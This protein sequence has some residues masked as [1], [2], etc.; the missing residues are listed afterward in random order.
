MKAFKIF[1][2]ISLVF[3]ALFCEEKIPEG[4]ERSEILKVRLTI[5]DNR[6][7]FAQENNW[8]NRFKL[9]PY[10]MRMDDY[11][12][13]SQWRVPF[14]VSVH[15][16]FDEAIDGRK[17]IFI[18]INLWPEDF[19][20]MWKAQLIYTDTSSTRHLTIPPGD[21][22]TLYTG[23]KL[24]WDQKDFNGKSIHR[25]N[26]FEPIWIECTEFDSFIK[27]AKNELVPWRYC[28]T[29]IL[30]PVDTVVV[31][32]QP[33]KLFAQAEIQIF[34]NYRIVK[35]DTVEFRIHYFFPGEG[36]RPKFWCEERMRDP[37]DPPCPFGFP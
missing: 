15:N 28:D 22:L 17:W 33:K 14:N 26:S 18:Q 24:T 20:E 12:K 31:F 32:G 11:V 7:D 34:K 19:N 8:E 9:P 2:I 21:S 29:L 36:F 16:D 1:A 37:T 5:H 13:L 6:Y 27:A 3:L 30:A 23:N 25:T 10:R 4:P 35:T